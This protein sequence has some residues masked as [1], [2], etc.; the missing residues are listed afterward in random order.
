MAFVYPAELATKLIAKQPAND[1]LVMLFTGDTQYHYPCTDQNAQCKQWSRSCHLAKERREH[2][3]IKMHKF[4]Q[5]QA[6]PAIEKPWPNI[7]YICHNGRSIHW[8]RLCQNGVRICE[9]SAAEM[10]F[11]TCPNAWAKWAKAK[12]ISHQRGFDQFWTLF[13]TGIV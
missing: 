12:G 3:K 9:W 1:S 2:V 6:F 5:I 8:P 10:H 7:E 4:V 11:P 13:P